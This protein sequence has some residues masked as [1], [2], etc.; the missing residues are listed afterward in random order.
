MKLS[1]YIYGF[2]TV[3][4]FLVASCSKEKDA[5]TFDGDPAVYFIYSTYASSSSNMDSISY[6][7]VEQ[8]LDVEADTLWLPVRISGGVSDRD[9]RVSLVAEA[10]ATTAQAGVHYKLPEYI[11][12]KDAFE[13]RLGVVLIRDASL[14]DQEKVLTLRITPT[15]DFPATMKE[16]VM[17]DGIY[18]SRNVIRIKFSDRLLKPANWESG[19]LNF[20]GSYSDV[21]FRFIAGTLG[22]SSFPTTGTGALK[23]P[24]L[25]F[26]QTTVRNALVAYN[27][28]NG[29]LIDENGQVVVIP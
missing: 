19:L 10:S 27:T 25:Q 3:L 16:T 26:Y 14:K 28:A 8:A 22:R 2:F 17:A 5:I 18:H 20:F 7:F 12:P 4:A 13:T 9:R 15:E 1:N 29:P 23:Y 21:K 24:D 11:I 6:T